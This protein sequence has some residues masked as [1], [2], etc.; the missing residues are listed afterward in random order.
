MSDLVTTSTVIVNTTIILPV[1]IR[2]KPSQLHTLH[3][4]LLF[5]AFFGC[6]ITI[7]GRTLCSFNFWQSQRMPRSSY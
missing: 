4:Q 6:I 2:A 5:A 1:A 3:T 7:K